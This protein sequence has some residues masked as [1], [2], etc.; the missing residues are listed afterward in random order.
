M[1]YQKDSIDI[2]PTRD[3][4]L[5]RQVLRSGFATGDQL[6]QFMSL[7]QC[8]HSREA[9][10]HRLRR[11][12]THDLVDKRQKFARGRRQVNSIS[13]D[14]AS[15]LIDTGEFFIGRKRV[16]VAQQSCIHWLDMN[17]LHLALWRSRTLIRWT[18]QSKISSQNMT[19]YR[20]A[21]DYDAVVS[22]N[23]QGRETPF[24]VEYERTPKTY[25]AYVAMARELEN[26]RLVETVVYLVSNFHLLSIVRD[27]VTPRKVRVCVA[28]YPEFLNELLATTVMVAGTSE[29]NLPFQAVL[30]QTRE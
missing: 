11:L 3:L 28:L 13:R 25:G 19:S 14:G 9:F 8:E 4:P 16:D 12:V 20:Y 18:A 22:V 2:S 24:A 5:L 7:N 10:D 21:K 1:R 6:F 17:E 26:E 27:H 30:A 23:C 29:R 15:V